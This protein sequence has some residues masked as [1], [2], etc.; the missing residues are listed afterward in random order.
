[1][2]TRYVKAQLIVLLCGGLVGPI[3]LAVY[4]A[5]GPMARPY[6]NWMFWTGL[7]ISALD[8]LIALA[9]TSRGAR[10]QANHAHLARAG[11]LVP[12]GITGISDTAWFVNDQQMIKVDLHLEVPGQP[13]F[14][15][16]ETMAASPTRM[17]ILNGRTL[18]A[19]VEPG[20]HN[21][22]IDWEASALVAGLVPARF[23][24]DS[25]HRTYD[26]TGQVGP[27]ID[28]LRVLHAN[29]IP[30]RG[31]IDVRSQPAVRE[32]VLD[33]VRRA[34]TAHPAAAAA[35]APVTVSQR[36]QE[37]DTL[38]ATG[39]ITEAEYAAKRRDILDDL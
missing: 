12:A 3:F 4:F 32:Q 11:V 28:I 27:L 38:R 16:R 30:V 26:L 19:L 37:L 17:Q 15:V 34:G 14:D 2:L 24:S 22:E 5:L 36:L 31:A 9:L 6:L 29:G 25:D 23:T 33:I 10:A 13:G 8:V 18:V 20:T 35:A 1:M 7:V 21:Y 39:A